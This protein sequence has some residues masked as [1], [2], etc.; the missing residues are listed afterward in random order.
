MVLYEEGIKLTKELIEGYEKVLNIQFSRDYIEFL[1]KSN[2][3]TP[4][5][6]FGFCPFQNY[7]RC[8]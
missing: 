2:G 7:Y 1:L 3:G 8:N 5:D 6:D 4:E